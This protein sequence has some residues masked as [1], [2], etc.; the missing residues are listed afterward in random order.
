MPTLFRFL[1]VCGVF[2]AIIYGVILS[3]VYLVEPRE[4]EVTIKI[5]SEQVNPPAP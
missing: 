3:L 4:R 5:P 2:A 1:F